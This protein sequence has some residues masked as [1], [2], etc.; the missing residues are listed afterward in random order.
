MT[1]RLSLF[2]KSN[3]LEVGLDEVARGCLVGRVYAA[4]VVWNPYLEEVYEYDE[5]ISNMINSIRDSKKLN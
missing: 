1:R 5:N 2:L 4:A 3:T